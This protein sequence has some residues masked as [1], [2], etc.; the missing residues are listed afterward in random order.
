MLLGY[1]RYH[2]VEP[3]AAPGSLEE[4]EQKVAVS[5]PKLFLIQY[6]ANFLSEEGQLT[7]SDIRQ[8]LLEKGVIWLH[9]QGRPSA[10]LLKTLGEIFGLH[11]LAL[12]DVN[13]GGQRPKLDLFEEQY[14]V[15]LNLARRDDNGAI[16]V[17]QISLFL[18][19]N[20][21]LSF[22]DGPTDYFEPVRERLRQKHHIR[23]RREDYLLYALIDL[24]IDEGFPI[25]DKLGQKL[26]DV[27]E[28][29]LDHPTQELRNEI[30]Y[31][32]RELIVLRRTW[33][34]Q[35]DMVNSLIRDGEARLTEVTRLYLRDC[36]D[37]STR[38][39]DFVE[40]YRDMTSSL[41][42]TYI[43]S[44]SQRM[45]DIMKV[46]TVIATIFMPLTFIVGI[47]GM[48]FDTASPWNLPELHWRY[49]Y[50]YCLGIMAAIAI[51]MIIYFRRKK[52]L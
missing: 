7:A 19:K 23:G 6:D 4:S 21:V 46:L 18:G 52:W 30:H 10:E 26:E 20:Y 37:H 28:D 42:D 5:P 1:P 2:R 27:E 12:E 9:C 38:M 3:G 25:L 43:S 41:L 44:V 51:G 8:S 24:V 13:N 32:K 34:P 14:F 47:Y 39:I 22:H 36:Y 29:V 49:G 35:R 48:N 15:I 17:D 50:F 16:A 45:N 31:I 11:P 33:W 40:T